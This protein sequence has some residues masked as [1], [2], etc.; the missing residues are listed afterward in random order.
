MMSSTGLVVTFLDEQFGIGK[1]QTIVAGVL[2]VITAILNPDGV[3]STSTGKGPAVAYFKARDALRTRVA[4]AQTRRMPEP[5]L[6]RPDSTPG[7]RPPLITDNR[8]ET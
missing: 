3:M 7:D 8:T 6:T 5:P 2:L 4:Q 1:Y